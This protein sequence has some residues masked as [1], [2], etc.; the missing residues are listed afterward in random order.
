[1]ARDDGPTP[2][3]RWY[4]GMLRKA[5]IERFVPQRAYSTRSARMIILGSLRSE[6]SLSL[7]VAPLHAFTV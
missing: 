2:A 5:S 4:D 6:G 1:M 7:P 3:P